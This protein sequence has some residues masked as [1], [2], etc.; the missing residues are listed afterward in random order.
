MSPSRSLLFCA[1]LLL[2]R[3]TLV[4]ADVPSSAAREGASPSPAR[5]TSGSEARPRDTGAGT[6]D[7]QG[8]PSTEDASTP[9]TVTERILSGIRRVGPLVVTITREARDL[10]LGNINVFARAARVAPA[11]LGD[12][13]LGYRL[14]GIR[15]QSV[16]AALGLRN[17]DVLRS[18]NGRPTTTPGEVLAAYGGLRG[19][20][21]WSVV[22]HRRGADVT[23]VV[24]VVDTAAEAPA[25]T[26]STARSATT[27]AAGTSSAGAR[28]GAETS[29]PS[30]SRR[31]TRGPSR[32][33]E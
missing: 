24:R 26:S 20:G 4:A 9:P 11:N 8:T 3:P 17:G 27:P 15:Q 21:A 28:D 12:G 29:P 23:L 33:R 30:V 16:V 22:V 5:A 1:A 32:A 18:I 13:M 2:T 10:A 25:G 31:S 6:T 7:P 14:S 19:A